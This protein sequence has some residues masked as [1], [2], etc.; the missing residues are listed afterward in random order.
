MLQAIARTGSSSP[1]IVDQ[2]QRR[3]VPSSIVKTLAC[4]TST[5]EG[6]RALLA[7]C[8]LVCSV[9]PSTDL[10]VVAM[11]TDIVWRRPDSCAP[12]I[13]RS[14]ANRHCFPAENSSAS[15]FAGPAD[16]TMR[17]GREWSSR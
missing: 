11:G 12:G 9:C 3:G 17:D 13:C 2:E 6:N 8:V 7:S 16:L 14:R 15:R 5:A 4:A 10:N 1:D